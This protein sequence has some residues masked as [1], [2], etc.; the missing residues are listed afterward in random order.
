MTNGEPMRSDWLAFGS[1][2][3]TGNEMKVVFGGQVMA[4]A[5]MKF[6]ESA[7]PIAVDYLNLGGAGKGKIS[8]GIL[9]WVGDEARFS[10]AAPGQPRPS[11]FEAMAKG[12]TLSRWR[13]K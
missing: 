2:T 9:D 6:D 11:S 7:S 10:I 1:R 3:T 5:K 13:K 12:I 8:L 4:H